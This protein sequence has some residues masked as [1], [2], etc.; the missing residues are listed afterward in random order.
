[1]NSMTGFANGNFKHQLGSLDVSAKSINSRF[2]E[3]R[4]HLDEA[5]SEFESDIRSLIKESINRSNLDIRLRWQVNK[6]NNQVC[7][8]NGKVL[9]QWVKTIKNLAHSNRVSFSEINMMDVLKLPGVL[10]Q[11]AESGL[12]KPPK[13]FILNSLKKV[14]LKLNLER[15]REG[16]VLKKCLL[17]I[18]QELEEIVNFL[19]MREDTLRKEL[20]KRIRGRLLALT[21]DLKVDG[22]RVQQ[23]ILFYLDKM[24]VREELTRLKEHLKAYKELLSK[25]GTIG[26]TLE[27]YSQELLREINTIGAK[28]HD[29]ELTKR[30]V[31]A[32][33]LVEGLR[34]QV[35]NV[36]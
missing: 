15:K 19:G 10:I 6:N 4:V 29:A 28:I 5:L 11:G 17:H 13:E 24:D 27:F 20:D 35:Q 21:N 23:E 14:I 31:I 22:H 32:K 16:L 25:G 26:K 18:I 3:V 34:E 30:I 36:E 12:N 9:D 1:M 33:T 2:L 8:I 7:A